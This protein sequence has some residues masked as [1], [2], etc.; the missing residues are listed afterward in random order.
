[1]KIKKVLLIPLGFMLIS[2]DPAQVIFF[3]NQTPKVAVV[4]VAINK[5]AHLDLREQATNDTIALEVQ[6]GQSNS[7]DF[8]IGDWPDEEIAK[9]AS[10]IKSIGI[11]TDGRKISYS[12]RQKIIE[13]FKQHREGFW[14][15]SEIIIPIE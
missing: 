1:M 2:C 5:N 8:G 12:S 14:A 10:G 3:E 4:K 11:E 15:K 9:V 7:I 6:P 13:L